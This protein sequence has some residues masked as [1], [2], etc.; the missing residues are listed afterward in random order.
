MTTKWIST[1]VLASLMSVAV[2]AACPAG[3]ESRGVTAGKERCALKGNYLSTELVL[4]SDNEYTL[5]EGVFFGADNKENSILRIQ[6]GTKIFGNPGSFVAIMRGSQIIAEGRKDA[7]IV[8]TSINTANPKRSDWGG[9]VINGNAPINACKTT[10][11]FCEAVSEGIKVQPVKFGGT[12]P[13]DNSGV[14]RYVRVEFGGYPISQD[15]ELNAFTFNGVGSGT[16]IEYIQAHMNSDDGVEFFGGTVSAKYV[17][18]TGIEDDSLDWDMGWVGKIQFLLADQGTDKVDNGIEADNLSS[19]MNATPRSNPEISNMTLIG[20]ANS[21]YG[22]LLRRGTAADLKNVIITGFGKGCIDIDDAETFVNGAAVQGSDV[23]ASG[24]KMTS[25]ILNCAKPYEAEGGDAWSTK[26]WFLSQNGNQEA[27]PKLNK[28][29]PAAGSP[30]LGAGL[31]PD[32]LFF[33]PVDFIGA[34]GSD[35]WT[36]GWTIQL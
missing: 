5:E 16:T 31:T 4:T 13:A 33:E 17:L 8:F 25:S 30:A 36:A 27:D 28:Y 35:D 24:L 10:A 7:P 19:P 3:T 11:T 1:V 2:N 32:D 21:A 22:M 9:L 29:S 12:D 26:T 15:N 6:A 23:V 34:I 20:S 14:L 18:L